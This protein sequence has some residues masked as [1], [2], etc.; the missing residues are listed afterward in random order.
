MPPSMPHMFRH[1]CKEAI[2][3]A[4]GEDFP[5]ETIEAAVLAAREAFDQ[6]RFPPLRK[7]APP[8][9]TSKGVGVSEALVKAIHGG[10]QPASRPTR[11]DVAIPVLTP[12]II[13]QTEEKKRQ[14][15]MRRLCCMDPPRFNGK[16]LA[17]QSEDWMRAIT[18]ILDA[19][20]ISLDS[21]MV[22]LFALQLDPTADECW[23][24]LTRAR[25]PETYTWDKSI[26][27]FYVRFFPRD[28]QQDL[29]DRLSSLRQGDNQ[30]ILD[31]HSM[32]I[33]LGRFA[34]NQ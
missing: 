30:S 24:G 23:E 27:A 6:P 2:R 3:V 4:A 22:K 15:Q 20:A 25:R 5:Q 34:P 8:S 11:T 18:K 14:R 17:V 7:G 31:Y 32:F 26:R 29:A 16:D 10:R 21:Y 9:R 33:Q 28:T 19:M 12:S 13:S 1:N